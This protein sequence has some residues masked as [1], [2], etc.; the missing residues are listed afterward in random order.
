[1][2]NFVNK[3]IQGNCIEEMQKIPEKTVDLIF[4]D[5]PYNLQLKQELKRPNLTTVDA[6]DDDWDKFEGFSDYQKFTHLWLS[7]CRRI[8]K[9]TGTI[10]VIGSY[11][12]IFQVGKIM[13]DL[14]YWT[15]NDVLWY[16]TNPM[17]NFRGTRFQNATETMIWALKNEDQKKYTFNYHTMKN[18]NDEKQ[19]KNVWEIPLCR[20]EERIM[21][22]GKKAHSTQK[23]EQL[24]FRVISSSSN[25]GD[26]VFDPFM[27]SGTTAAVAKKLGRSYLGIEQEEKYIKIIEERLKK[28]DTP[29]EN[30]DESLFI[31][32]SKKNRPKV[33]FAEL[34]ET[35]YLDIG[36]ELS[37]KNKKY[38]AKIAID[39]H[40]ISDDIR[41]SIHKVGAL[42]QEIEACNGWDFWYRIVNG[43][44][45]N[46]D[47]YRE[48]YLKDRSLI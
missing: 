20:G 37:S 43:K 13:H 26:L 10:W 33:S 39:G 45:I 35:G 27:G 48:Q 31:T 47:I 14:G 3:I 42:V 46:I 41:G 29:D 24:L 36:D 17:P 7:E 6:V 19:M 16:K 4:A 2:S 8:L 11:H 34:I 44:L 30:L 25:K 38:L 23:P 22:D 32:P 5:P 9:E 1:M 12:N 18:I 21:V 40:I 15:L 28:I